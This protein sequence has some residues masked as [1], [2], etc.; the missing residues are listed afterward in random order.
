MYLWWVVYSVFNDSKQYTAPRFGLLLQAAS[1]SRV[2]SGGGSLSEDG[3]KD[4]WTDDPGTHWATGPLGLS[5]G[6]RLLF[7]AL[8]LVCTSGRLDSFLIAS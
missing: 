3:S 5:T 1:H 2:I 4:G 8:P 7:F 6:G